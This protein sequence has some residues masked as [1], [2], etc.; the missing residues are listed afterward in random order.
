MWA[1]S[2]RACRFAVDTKADAS[3]T[4]SLESEPALAARSAP[5]VNGL[6]RHFD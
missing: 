2:T 3:L 4:F 1:A 6:G 5:A